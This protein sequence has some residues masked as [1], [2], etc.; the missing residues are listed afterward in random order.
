M[1]VPRAAVSALE[2]WYHSDTRKPLVIRGAR[3]TGK[4]TAVDT[5]GRTVGQYVYLNLE[6]PEDR[7]LFERDLP[8]QQLLRAIY[9]EKDADPGNAST[10]IFI[11]EIQSSPS[12]IGTLRHF[13]EYPEAPPVV[14]A[15]SLLEVYLSR[16]E[17][18]FP[19]GRV[20][21]L[22]LYPVRFDEFLAA[23][24]SPTLSDALREVPCPQFA[25]AKLLSAFHE[26]TLVGGMPA[27]A[28]DYI[29]HRDAHRLSVLYD[30]LLTSFE[31]DAGTYA[32]SPA[33]YQVLRHGIESAPLEAGSRIKFQG[34]GNSAYRSREMGEA[35][36][37]LER[38]MILRLSYPVTST[39]PP[40]EPNRKRSPRLHFL[41]TGLV[42]HAVGLAAEYV[43]LADLNDL[44]RG[45][46]AEHVV[47]QE[48]QSREI[49]T[50]HPVRFWTSESPTN[51]AEVDFVLPFG[52]V[53]LPV[54]VKSGK[55]GR[56]R[57]LHAFMD[58]VDHDL[59]VR[60]YRGPVRVDE[61]KSVSGRRFRL[62]N[63]PYYLA[64]RVLE[65]VS[66]VGV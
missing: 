49:T 62:L 9:L 56:L 31:D 12:A 4:T 40:F 38:A 54:E 23:Y 53:L 7:A 35:L 55:A 52:T 14:A 25:H 3:Q 50:R 48:L 22:Y 6:R 28:A 2:T 1:Y 27:A 17:E 47:A 30:A 36:R 15:G 51:S 13:A 60:L 24:G 46:I 42:N 39:S 45:R 19:V 58:H 32:R 44:Y 11:D 61:I 8:F 63:L 41:D 57:S 37:T 33:Q 26:Y 20:Q 21:Y 66:W 59:A 10:L 18:S 29:E 65:Y 16:Y 64:S 43:G 34:F 5:F